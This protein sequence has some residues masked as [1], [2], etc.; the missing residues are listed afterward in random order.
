M[1]SQLEGSCAAN[2]P[3]GCVTLRKLDCKFVPCRQAFQLNDRMG[4]MG[5]NAFARVIP[6]S[7]LKQPQSGDISCIYPIT[8]LCCSALTT[9]EP[10]IMVLQYPWFRT[11][12]PPPRCSP[13][14]ANLNDSSSRHT[15]PSTE[16]RGIQG[17]GQ[18]QRSST[19]VPC[20]LRL[21]PVHRSKHE[22]S[23]FYRRRNI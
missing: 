8:L 14:R 13:A 5:G 22:K 20:C 3:Q 15:A 18:L 4:S 1:S 6:L 9:N 7:R 12:E 23:D 19:A 16:T 17:C 2:S 11:H 10:V 21:K